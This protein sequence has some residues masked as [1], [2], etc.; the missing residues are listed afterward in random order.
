MGKVVLKCIHFWSFLFTIK[1]ITCICYAGYTVCQIMFKGKDFHWNF[2]LT[3]ITIERGL[4]YAK[5][6]TI[7]NIRKLLCAMRNIVNESP[8]Q[9]AGYENNS[10]RHKD[11]KSIVFGFYMI[12]CKCVTRKAQE[13]WSKVLEVVE[14]WSVE[15]KDK[16]FEWGNPKQNKIYQVLLDNWK[17]LFTSLFYACLNRKLWKWTVCSTDSKAAIVFF[18]FV[19]LSLKHHQRYMQ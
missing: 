16:P 19:N 12:D 17:Y 4:Q 15:W 8:F 5:N 10:L 3:Y 18:I 1:N 13:V 9:G 11:T 14:L 2:C 7:R 6:A